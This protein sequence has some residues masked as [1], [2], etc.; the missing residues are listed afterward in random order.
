MHEIHYLTFKGSGDLKKIQRECDCYAEKRTDY[1]GGLYEDIRFLSDVFNSEEEAYN[2]LDNKPTGDYKQYAVKFKKV[3]C[4]PTKQ[5][6]EKSAKLK[7]MYT[8]Y[9]Q[10][11]DTQHYTVATVKSEYISCK[12]C[13]SK[14]AVRYLKNNFCPLCHDDLRP[15]T[16]LERLQTMESNIKELQQQVESLKR[17]EN[18]KALEKTRNAET[19]WLVRIEYHT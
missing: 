2:F 16:T 17:K 12:C 19:Y 7:E 9:T 3:N 6:I 14:L 11:K 18:E 15:K 4:K 8:K 5:L 13:G 1:R 10:L